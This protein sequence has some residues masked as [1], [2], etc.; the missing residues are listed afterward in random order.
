MF[1]LDILLH[2]GQGF[3]GGEEVSMGE[4][5]TPGWYNGFIYSYLTGKR[6]LILAYFLPR[7][8]AHE[9]VLL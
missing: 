1:Y 7:F 2:F 9:D 6:Y 4:S 5:P 3:L 8:N